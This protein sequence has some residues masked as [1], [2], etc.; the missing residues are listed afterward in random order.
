MPSV[1][2]IRWKLLACAVV[3]VLAI[4]SGAALAVVLALA[5]VTAGIP[6]AVVTVGGVRLLRLLCGRP[7]TDRAHES[8]PT[9][10]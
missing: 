4:V 8:E 7:P 6:V 10:T 1:A 3:C 9:A 2:R 5:F